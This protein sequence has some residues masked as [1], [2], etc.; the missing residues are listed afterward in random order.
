MNE[1]IR[2]LHNQRQAIIFHVWQMLNGQSLLFVECELFMELSERKT[3]SAHV[4]PKQN[5]SMG[6]L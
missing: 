4:N 3:S 5:L 2:T 1:T 6:L